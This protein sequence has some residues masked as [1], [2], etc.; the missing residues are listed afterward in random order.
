MA[1]LKRTG[2]HDAKKLAGFYHIQYP[3]A[4]LTARRVVFYATVGACL[5]ARLK[6]C[7]QRGGRCADLIASIHLN[8]TPPLKKNMSLQGNP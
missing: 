1:L 7:R 5:A 4:R 3:C 6:A 2:S 8:I